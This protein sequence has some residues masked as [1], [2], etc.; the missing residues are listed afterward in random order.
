LVALPLKCFAV[1]RFLYC[2]L[3]NDNSTTVPK[4]EHIWLRKNYGKDADKENINLLM[5]QLNSPQQNQDKQKPNS[6]NSRVSPWLARIVYPLGCY[7]V[8]PL[9][10]G[11]IEVIGRENIPKTGAVI[12]APTHRSYWDALIIAYA[13]GRL[14]S[15]R[16]LRFMTSIDHVEAPIKGWFIRH[17]GGFPVDTRNPRTDTVKHSAELL[18]DEEMLV[19]FPEGGIFRDNQVHS[20]KRGVAYIALDVASEQPDSGVKI[21]PISIK[22]SQPYPTWGTDVKVEIGS[23]INVSDYLSDSLRQSSCRLTKALQTSLEQIHEQRSLVTSSS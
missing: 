7:M 15:G 1:L 14:A 9:F 12:V 2:C 11:K 23:P 20:L 16:D 10:F 19:I 5:I 8:M 18:F 22:Y 4:I 13:V 3:D 6:I 21:L 17:L